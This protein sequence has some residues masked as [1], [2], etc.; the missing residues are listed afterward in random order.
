MGRFI[1]RLIS[2]ELP[3]SSTCHMDVILGPPA[4]FRR[5]RCGACLAA[6]PNS[7]S[8]AHVASGL[9]RAELG[10]QSNGV[11]VELFHEAWASLEGRGEDN[12]LLASLIA[13]GSSSSLSVDNCLIC[14][15]PNGLLIDFEPMELIA[16]DSNVC[17]AHKVMEQSTAMQEAVKFPRTDLHQ[18][19][20]ASQRQIEE[21]SEVYTCNMRQT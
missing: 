18:V 19:A 4:L 21:S 11:L 2:A 7:Q 3:S 1:D 16:L 10:G 14:V 12:T 15:S 5:R 8:V 13:C 20:V 6:N 17:I 9:T